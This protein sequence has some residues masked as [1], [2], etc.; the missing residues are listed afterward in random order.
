MQEVSYKKNIN[1]N[2]KMRNLEQILCDSLK[3]WVWKQDWVSFKGL[4]K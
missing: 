1:S 3:V 2:F 4:A